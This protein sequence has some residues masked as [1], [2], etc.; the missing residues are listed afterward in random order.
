MPNK[1][2]KRLENLTSELEIQLK[3]IYVQNA[4]EMESMKA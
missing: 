3:N 2:V 1:D 4:Q